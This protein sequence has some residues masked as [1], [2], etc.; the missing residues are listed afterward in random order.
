[1]ASAGSYASL[2]LAPDRQ[3][4]QHPTNQVFYTPDALPAA[5]PTASKHWMHWILNKIKEVFTHLLTAYIVTFSLLKHLFPRRLLRL[6]LISSAETASSSYLV[7]QQLYSIQQAHS[8]SSPVSER[9]ST[10]VSVGALH[11]SLECW[12]PSPTCHTSFP[13]QHLRPSSILSCWPDGLELTPGLYP[14]SNEQHRLF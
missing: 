5:Q 10:T 7:I 1:M 2:H 3:P 13:A 11:S 12:Q 8:D 6:C 9:P 4:C 14:G